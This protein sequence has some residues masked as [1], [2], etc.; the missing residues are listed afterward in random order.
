MSSEHSKRMREVAMGAK[1]VVVPVEVSE[2]GFWSVLRRLAEQRVSEANIVAGERL[3]E[4]VPSSGGTMQFTIRSIRDQSDSIECLL[5]PETG[6]LTCKTGAA[7]NGES[8]T[9]QLLGGTCWTMQCAGKNCT[10]DDVIARML[11]QLIW[12][13]DPT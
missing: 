9:F 13:E 10:I 12:I 7:I 5:C 6:V 8:L 2:N 3:W 11:D 4:L 1:A